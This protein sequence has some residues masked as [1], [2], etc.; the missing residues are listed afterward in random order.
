MRPTPYSK[1]NLTICF[2]K[3]V[4]APH[5]CMMSDYVLIAQHLCGVA[6]WALT[7]PFPNADFLFLNPFCGRFTFD[8]YGCCLVVL[9]NLYQVSTG[10]QPP[11]HYP[12]WYFRE[13]K[14][15]FPLVDGKW[16]S[17]SGHSITG[18]Q[19]TDLNKVLLK[20]LVSESTNFF[21]HRCEL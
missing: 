15:N 4:L 11:W 12:V 10:G 14:Y 18:I 5:I 8:V 1:G 19:T 6:V 17:S 21:I 16:S 2:C 3:T 9:H 13:W 7:V 20:E